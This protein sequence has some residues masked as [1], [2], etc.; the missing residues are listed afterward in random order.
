MLIIYVDA[1]LSAI[2]HLFRA[3]LFDAFGE[4]VSRILLAWSSVKIQLCLLDECQLLIVVPL[5]TAIEGPIV[6]GGAQRIGVV[7]K[8]I[9]IMDKHIECKV[10]SQNKGHAVVLIQPDGFWRLEGIMFAKY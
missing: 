8:E 10:P 5:G 4:A 7:Q 2:Y 9:F 1:L 3:V 6:A